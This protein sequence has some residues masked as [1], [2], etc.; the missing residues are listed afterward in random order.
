LIN[1]LNAFDMKL[2]EVLESPSLDPMMLRRFHPNL[3]TAR[4]NETWD[5]YTEHLG[6]RTVAEWDIY[7]HLEHPN[8]A[9]LGVLK[10]EVDGE[11]PELV[12]ATD[13]RGF[14]LS[15]DVA[16]ADAEYERLMKAGVTIVAPPQDK[17]W[18]ERL[19]VVRDP[20][21]VLI[22]VAHRVDEHQPEPVAEL[23]GV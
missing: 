1:T 16:D 23:A 15:L 6:F 22:F 5:F 3:V 8:G 10:E 19:F 14:W 17:P 12:P 7:V 9:Q 18:G 2:S 13:G 21:G 20:N 4:F 11:L